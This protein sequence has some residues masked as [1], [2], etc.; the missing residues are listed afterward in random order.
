MSHAKRLLIFKSFSTIANTTFYLFI[1]IWEL[2]RQQ[3]PNYRLPLQKNYK[4]RNREEVSYV[5]IKNIYPLK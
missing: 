1:P 5:Q 3:L 4:K 2:G